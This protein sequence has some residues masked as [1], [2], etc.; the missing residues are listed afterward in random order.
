MIQTRTDEEIS[1]ML[2]IPGNRRQLDT[3][4]NPE[5]I[6]LRIRT[7]L[8]PNLAVAA[9]KLLPS[10]LVNQKYGAGS[11]EKLNWLVAALK[12]LLT[13]VYGLLPLQDFFHV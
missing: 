7:I 6:F 1:L 2:C 4:I 5:L 12:Y 9:A 10:F 3:Y 8:L 11:E 13:Y